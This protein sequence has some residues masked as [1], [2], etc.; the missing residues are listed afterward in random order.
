MC[1]FNEHT[2]YLKFVRRCYKDSIQPRG[3]EPDACE[4][5]LGDFV[6]KNIRKLA[7]GFILKG[8]SQDPA[9]KNGDSPEAK[10]IAADLLRD[11][12]LANMVQMER[13]SLGKDGPGNLEKMMTD[14]E[15]AKS[16]SRGSAPILTSKGR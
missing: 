1:I 4:K 12:V 16:F 10:V 5:A 13:A 2:P 11:C 7:A 15:Q 6:D 3:A 14:P 9:Y 8:G